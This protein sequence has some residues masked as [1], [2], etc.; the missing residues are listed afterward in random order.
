LQAGDEAALYETAPGLARGELQAVGVLQRVLTLCSMG[1]RFTGVSNHGSM[2]EHQISH[3]IDM[4]AGQ[5][6]PGTVHGQQVGVASLVMARLQARLLALD[7]PPRVRATRID[8]RAYVQRYGEALAPLCL[9]ESRKTAL[10][11]AGAKAFNA[12]LA[13]LWPRSRVELAPMAVPASRMEAALKAAGGPVTGTEL[14]LPVEVWR[15][16]IRHAREI[17]GRWSFLNLA[18]DAGLLDDFVAGENSMRDLAEF[19][20]DAA[21]RLLGVLTDIDDTMTSRGPAAGSSLWRAGAARRR[22][23]SGGADH[24]PAGRLV[25]HDRE[26]LAGGGRRGRKRRLLVSL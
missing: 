15:N 1:V 26:I 22:G 3:W 21:G 17:R 18:A 7:T 10:D 25:R 23:A 2:G 13:A 16:A 9:A 14:G 24:R 20:V 11:E 8:E 19:P 5:A 4:F 6:H 12:K